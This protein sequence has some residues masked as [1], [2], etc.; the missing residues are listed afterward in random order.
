MILKSVVKEIGIPPKAA[1]KKTLQEERGVTDGSRG[2]GGHAGAGLTF[3][4]GTVVKL[5]FSD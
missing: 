5:S 1:K 3:T 2:G 4:R